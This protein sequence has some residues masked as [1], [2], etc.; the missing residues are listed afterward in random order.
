M[1]SREGSA[2]PPR[3]PGSPPRCSGA[4][5]RMSLHAT[6]L[7]VLGS[8][9]LCLRDVR[10]LRNGN[11]PPR[12]VARHSCVAVD[13]DVDKDGTV[14]LLRPSKLLA[15]VLGAL[16]TKDVGTERRRVRCEVDR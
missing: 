12:L 1:R 14:D 15:Q 4:S 13:L 6:S 2:C 10:D 11:G 8:R 16:R 9:G 5:E 3:E 7:L